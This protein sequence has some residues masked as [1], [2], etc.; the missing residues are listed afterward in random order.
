MLKELPGLQTLTLRGWAWPCG[1][2]REPDLGP[3]RDGVLP[4]DW[5]EL[6][7][8]IKS[9]KLNNVPE[10]IQESVTSMTW[11]LDLNVECHHGLIELK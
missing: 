1:P 6:L 4:P 2:H 7:T 10:S 3:L 11:L 9:L 5:L 8:S